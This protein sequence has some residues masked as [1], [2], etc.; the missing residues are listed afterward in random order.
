MHE[1]LLR[2][3]GRRLELDIFL[4][5]EN[6]AFEYQGEQHYYDV[7]SMGSLWYQKHRDT[8]KELACENDNITL[9]KI[10]FWWDFEKDS[11]RATIHKC[12]PDLL[13]CGENVPIPEEPPRD[14]SRGRS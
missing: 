6:V 10:P 13:I 12:R 7:H 1:G 2:D 4:P 14:Y 8:E 11:L 9:I 3:T 5:K